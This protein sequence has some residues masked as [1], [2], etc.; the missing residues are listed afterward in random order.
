MITSYFCSSRESRSLSLKMI[1]G[2][3]SSDML[4]SFANIMSI[5][6]RN[7]IVCFWEGYLR[8]Y[9]IV[10][11]F[12]WIWTISYV[13]YRQARDFDDTLTGKYKTMFLLNHLC[14]FIFAAITPILGFL[15]VN[16]WYGLE[17]KVYCALYPNDMEVYFG[18]LPIFI[19]TLLTLLNVLKLICILRNKSKKL[20]IHS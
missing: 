10:S 16:T 2:L 1:M 11:S 5:M 3:I 6:R 13:S 17:E 9:S 8:Q 18:Y 4:Y 7:P 14:S 12:L 20:R 15:G 19:F